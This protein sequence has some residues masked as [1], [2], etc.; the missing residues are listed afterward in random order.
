MAELVKY[1]ACCL[2]DHPDLVE[3]GRCPATRRSSWSSA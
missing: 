2:V 3:V 1:I